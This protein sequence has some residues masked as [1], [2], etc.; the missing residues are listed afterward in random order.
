MANLQRKREMKGER[1]REKRQF[2]LHFVLYGVDGVALLL[3][4]NIGVGFFTFPGSKS[5]QTL[6]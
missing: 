1:K 5:W 4:Y 3:F 6:N 2:K